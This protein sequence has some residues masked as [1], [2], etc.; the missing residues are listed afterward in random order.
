MPN[1]KIALLTGLASLAIAVVLTVSQ[2]PM[3]VAAS[4][5]VTGSEAPI[6][7][8][9]HGATYC[10][11]HETLPRDTKAIR[12]WL[13]AAAGPRVHAVVIAAGH[14]VVSGTR[15]SIWIGGSVT[16]P[17]RPLPRTIRNVEV[18]VSFVLHDETIVVQGMPA[19]APLA[20][21]DRRQVLGGKMGIEFLRAGGRSWLSLASEIA[22]RMGLGRAP[23]G[24]WVAL[25]ALA[26]LGTAIAL[27][28]RL[29]VR[30]LT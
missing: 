21:H 15:G 20:A 16:I 25:A 9:T 29:I 2:S 4:N 3:I 6:W 27:S 28:S 12:V 7:T 10:Q 11:A 26:L 8:T 14:T 18:C 13:D 30:E 17:V 1:T 19:P 23:A 5:K 22:R 24:T